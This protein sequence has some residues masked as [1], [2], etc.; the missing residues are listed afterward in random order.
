MVTVPVADVERAKAFYVDQVGFHEDMDVR[1]DGNR[2]FV[3]LTP[4]GSARCV[5]IGEGWIDSAPRSLQGTRRHPRPPAL[6]RRI[7]VGD[8]RDMPDRTAR[9]QSPASATAAERPVA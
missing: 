2:R 7:A 5:A 6:D 9:N 1:T 8:V 3:R 4:P